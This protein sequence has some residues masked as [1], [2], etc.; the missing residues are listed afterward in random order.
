MK[1]WQEK[2]KELE[3]FSDDSYQARRI[4]ELVQLAEGIDSNPIGLGTI[5]ITGSRP[6]PRIWIQAQT[7]GDEP[8]TTMAIHR[9]LHDITP[10]ELAGVLVLAPAMHATAVRHHMREAPLDGKNG[11]RIWGL[12]WSKLG[13]T[14]VF[15]YIW[16][17]RVSTIIQAFKPD[18][19][20]DMHD[21]GIPLRIMSHALYNDIST[22]LGP[23]D[24]LCWDSG[25]KVIW[26]SSGGRFAGNVGA[27]M[28]TLGIPSV[29]LESGG[30]G[31]FIE[32][33][34]QEM[35]I[36]LRNVL[37]SMK[38]LNGDIIPR[39]DE[40]L[41]MIAGNWVR[42]GRAGYFQAVKA[43]GYSLEE[44]EPI[45]HI[46]NLFGE[47]IETIKSPSSGILFGLRYSA[48]A[49]VGDYIAN[50]GTLSERN[51]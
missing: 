32:E 27:H 47:T 16:M 14:K 50:V 29:M 43:L 48:A 18:L 23:V 12:D 30:T 13:H 31:Q 8:N 6:G 39:V 24:R 36:G 35:A 38:M 9:L 1:T 37:I 42:A 51:A 17:D 44:G 49:N 45:G 21:G 3:S 34:I 7:H 40:Q 41:L 2:I 20:I 22:E 25:M 26:A 46:I 33:D 15:S 19:V 28:H 5:T 11:N 10:E 4:D